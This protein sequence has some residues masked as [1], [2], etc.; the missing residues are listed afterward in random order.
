VD[1]T[2]VAATGFTTEDTN[3]IKVLLVSKTYAAKHLLKMIPD[4]RLSLCWQRTFNHFQLYRIIIH[5][6][7]LS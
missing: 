5:S 6:A 7:I 3:F 2:A 4:R 1:K